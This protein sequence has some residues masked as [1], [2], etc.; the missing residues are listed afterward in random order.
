MFL[1]SK[2]EKLEIWIFFPCEQ[3]SLPTSEDFCMDFNPI[4]C[5]ECGCCMSLPAKD[6]HWWQMHSRHFCKVTTIS[7]PQVIEMLLENPQEARNISLKAPAAFGLYF[8]SCPK[9]SAL[10][11]P[12]TGVG[13]YACLY[14]LLT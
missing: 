6:P 2:Q 4:T 5:G 10:N 8:S 9:H 7:I 13:L 3:S 14:L 1:Q 11:I 12:N